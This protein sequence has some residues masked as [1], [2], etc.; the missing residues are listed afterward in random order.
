M[1]KPLVIHPL[2]FAVFPILALYAR[3]ARTV[4]ITPEFGA[5]IGL[6]ILASIILFVLSKLLMKDRDKAGL[7][8]SLAMLCFFSFGR[9]TNG[10]R[11]MSLYFDDR[12]I[13]LLTLI[14]LIIIFIL[15]MRSKKRFF[16][17]TKILNGAA[18]A[19]VM[20]NLAISLWA[21]ISGAS[22][23]VPQETKYSAVHP[24][25]PNI[26]FIVLDAYARADVL[27]GI[28]GID[29]SVLIKDLERRGFYVASQSPA[30]YCQTSLSLACT[31][32]LGYLDKVAAAEGPE[33]ADKRPLVRMIQH[34][35]VR[36][37]LKK[38]G[39]AFIAFPSGFSATEIRDAD[40]YVHLRNPQSE[41][42]AAL[43]ETTPLPILARYYKRISDFEIH[44]ERILG[45]F[46]ALS[47]FRYPR[48]PF[49]VFAHIIC[50]HPPFVFGAE[51]EPKTP[52]REYTINDGSDLLSEDKINIG[53]YIQGYRDQVTFINTKIRETVD[54]ILANSPTPPIIILESDHGPKAFFDTESADASNLRESMAVFNAIYLP[55]R[56][57]GDLYP[58]ISPVN[59]FTALMNR[60]TGDKK[61]FLEDRSFYSTEK[62]PY[63]FV[64]FDPKTYSKIL[65]DF[66]KSN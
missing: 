44:R 58:G 32:N 40:R 42:S 2:L 35:Q 31:M 5:T 27:A 34:S 55:G 57:Y 54:G 20:F 39:Y 3:N 28:Y 48:S 63:D 38:L 47:S 43:E 11:R 22:V 10:L 26:Y 19:L 36:L 53:E 24:N 65:P 13:L 46:H 64:P 23:N 30:N 41:F 49:F 66:R 52:D 6:A 12:I 16:F 21:L 62:R 9:I 45:V 29:N 50:P 51:G 59:T 25:L 37:I 33:S 61:P 14:C 60:I 8:A 17:V 15:I 56:D 1:K 7:F 18:I 4:P